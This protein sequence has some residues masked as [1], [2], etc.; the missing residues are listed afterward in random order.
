[1]HP[2][3]DKYLS[4]MCLYYLYVDYHEVGLYLYTWTSKK[5][6]MSVRIYIDNRMSHIIVGSWDII[7]IW[8]GKK[9][10]SAYNR[11][12]SRIIIIIKKI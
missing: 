1:M 12:Q 9:Y 3:I 5:P 8:S 4:A 7:I 11:G 10:L 2:F 6:S